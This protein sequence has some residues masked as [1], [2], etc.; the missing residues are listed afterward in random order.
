[1]PFWQ[2]IGKERRVVDMENKNAWEKYPEGEARRKVM[3]FAEG[4]RK[5]ISKCKTERECMQEFV[6]LAKEAGFA[7]IDQMIE[8]GAKVKPGDKIYAGNM[9]KAAAFFLLWG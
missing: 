2:I 9:G 1:M 3:D 6:S 5:F 8:K 4:Y 7:D